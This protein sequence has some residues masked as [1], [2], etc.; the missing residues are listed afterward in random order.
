MTKKELVLNTFR[1][2]GKTTAQ[3]IQEKASEMTGTELYDE[4]FFIPSFEDAR[5][6]KNMLERKAGFVCL[7][8]SGRVVELIQPYDS[9][10]YAGDPETLTA[11][12]RFKWSQNPKHARPFICSAESYY[13]MDDCCIASDG[14]VRRSK[15]DVNT[16][17]PMVN[18][19]FWEVVEV[20]E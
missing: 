20:T 13:R 4:S 2:Y 10:I 9:D 3:A 19:E 6:K 16:Y 12:W 17:D 15:L 11:H 7:S 18:P 14:T 1:R 8:P 5:K